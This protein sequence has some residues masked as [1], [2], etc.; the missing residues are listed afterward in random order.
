MWCPKCGGAT[1]VTDSR[2]K[3]DAGKPRPDVYRFRRC[4]GCGQRF[5]TYEIARAKGAGCPA[6][7]RKYPRAGFAQH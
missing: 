2:N 6:G 4:K 5:S 7:H 1:E 3:N